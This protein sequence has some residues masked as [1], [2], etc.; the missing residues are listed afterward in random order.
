MAKRHRCILDR[1]KARDIYKLKFLANKST[2]PPNAEGQ[3]I[4][5]S[6]LLAAQY[7]V[8]SKTIRDIW[9]RKIWTQD[10]ADLYDQEQANPAEPSLDDQVRIHLSVRNDVSDLTPLSA[11]CLSIV[12]YLSVRNDF[13]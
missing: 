13:F 1:N 10:T 12:Q 2:S 3:A 7:G 9:Q 11:L 8:A 5:I 6:V 4:S